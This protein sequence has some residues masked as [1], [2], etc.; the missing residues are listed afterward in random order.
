MKMQDIDLG[1]LRCFVTVAETRSFTIA[2]S[3]LGRS[4]SAISVRVKKLEDLIGC[5]L[6]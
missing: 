2:G 3:R 5:T 4:Q 6:L 1:L